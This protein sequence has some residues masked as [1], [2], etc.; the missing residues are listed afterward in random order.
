MEYIVNEEILKAQL[1]LVKLNELLM[2]LKE[3]EHSYM[4]G[5]LEKLNYD[6]EVILERF[7][8]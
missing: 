6:L 5:D 2:M 3:H 4:I 1:K 8:R 7:T